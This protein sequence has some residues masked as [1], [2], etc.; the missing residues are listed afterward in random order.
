MSSMSNALV[1]AEVKYAGLGRR[2]LALLLD[3]VLFCAFFF[4]VTRLVKGVWLMSP[5]DH[6][7]VNGWFIFDPLCLIF[8]VIMALYMILL[9]G[10][11]GTTVG[12]WAVGLRVVG[13]DGHRPGLW[14]GAL[15]NALRVVDSLPAFNILGVILISCSAERARFGDRVAGTRVIEARSG[16]VIQEQ[17]A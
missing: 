3:L 16:P 11:L 2:F 1:G 12:K 6:N 9:E 7:W 8:L 13:T 17:V 14:K 4:P 5:N 10:L 15:R